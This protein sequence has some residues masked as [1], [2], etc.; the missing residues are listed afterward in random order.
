MVIQF[1]VAP[2]RFSLSFS[3]STSLV[4]WGLGG[5]ICHCRGRLGSH[6][7]VGELFPF[8]LCVFGTFEAAEHLRRP[9]TLTSNIVFGSQENSS[10]KCPVDKSKIDV[11][12][13]IGSPKD[14]QERYQNLTVKD[15]EKC[16]KEIIKFSP[17]SLSD[18]CKQSQFNDILAIT[19]FNLN[20][21]FERVS[22]KIDY[23]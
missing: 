6:A 5:V 11:T 17:V 10:K 4:S 1:R 12:L 2:Y 19:D 8:Q 16:T 15:D 20:I 3:V 9:Y 7:S 13:S 22:K 14:A 18:D 23:L 21:K